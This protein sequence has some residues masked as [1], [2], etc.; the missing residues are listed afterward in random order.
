MY[1]EHRSCATRSTHRDERRIS[2]CFY[3]AMCGQPS[4][5]SRIRVRFNNADRKPSRSSITRIGNSYDGCTCDFKLR[6]NG[7]KANLRR[8]TFSFLY[9]SRSLRKSS[10]STTQQIPRYMYA[11]CSSKSPFGSGTRHYS[12]SARRTAPTIVVSG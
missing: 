12:M 11:S 8:I 1:L 3:A 9:S 10:P 6:N 5:R 7:L 4:S 2:A